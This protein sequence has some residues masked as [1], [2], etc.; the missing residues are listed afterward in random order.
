METKESVRS[1]AI[2]HE[3]SLAD[4]TFGTEGKP[5]PSILTEFSDQEKRK[6]LRRVDWRLLPIVGAVYCISLID[7]TNRKCYPID[8]FWAWANSYTSR[9]SQHCWV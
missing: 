5:I 7:R 9:R 2:H 4:D 1:D 8:Q 3:D 6:I